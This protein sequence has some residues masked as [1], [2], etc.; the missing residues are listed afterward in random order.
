MDGL[1]NYKPMMH[2]GRQEGVTII[3]TTKIHL[4]S[5]TVI[6]RAA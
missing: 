6:V 3:P 1:N 2:K 4:Q 5:N